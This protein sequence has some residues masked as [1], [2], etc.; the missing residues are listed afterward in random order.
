[1]A[2][3]ATHPPRFVLFVNFPELMV[4]S[5]KKY[6]INQ[7]REE[8][9]FKGVPL[10]FDL[11]GKH[12]R[13]LDEPT[14]VVTKHQQGRQGCNSRYPCLNKE[15]CHD[16]AGSCIRKGVSYACHVESDDSQ[17]ILMRI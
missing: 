14:V 11:R 3:V 4:D 12:Q 9:S 2:Q 16:V 5:Y 7:F 6:M 1:M 13:D 15:R 10:V 17:Q 8:Y